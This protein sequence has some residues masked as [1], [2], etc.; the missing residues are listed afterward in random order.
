MATPPRRFFA[1]VRPIEVAHTFPDGLVKFRRSPPE[2]NCGKVSA[3]IARPDLAG[4]RRP[5][6]TVRFFKPAP[7]ALGGRVLNRPRRDHTATPQ[8]PK[9]SPCRSCIATLQC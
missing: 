1:Y 6:A 8:R 5:T 4:R 2:G 9:S 3:K 7:V